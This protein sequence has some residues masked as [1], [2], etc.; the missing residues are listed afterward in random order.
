MPPLSFMAFV[1]RI[2]ETRGP[3]YNADHKVADP[4]TPIDLFGSG[5]TDPPRDGDFALVNH[6]P[7]MRPSTP[8]YH[9]GPPWFWQYDSFLPPEYGRIFQIMRASVPRGTQ[10]PF[11]DR[12]NN[13]VA[14]D[15]PN[16]FGRIANRLRGQR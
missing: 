11:N 6:R 1:P 14:A 13:D 10:T 15:T 8:N 7:A 3:T 16:A 9:F 12:Q 2:E 4:N 5:L